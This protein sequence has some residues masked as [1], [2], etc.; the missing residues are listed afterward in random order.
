M[1]AANSTYLKV[2]FQWLNEALCF[3]SSLVIANSLVIRYPFFA[4]P[5]SKIYPDF[6]LIILVIN[7][8]K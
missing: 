1:L 4:K 3:V 7:F 5:H 8:G 2:A 6:K